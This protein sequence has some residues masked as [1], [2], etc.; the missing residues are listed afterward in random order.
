MEDIETAGEDGERIIY[1]WMKKIH[2]AGVGKFYFKK[3]ILFMLFKMAPFCN[4]ITLRYF[5][6]IK[7]IML[8]LIF[9]GSFCNVCRRDKGK[10]IIDFHRILSSCMAVVEYIRRKKLLVHSNKL[11]WSTYFPFLQ[12]KIKS[13]MFCRK[14][15]RFVA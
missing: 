11:H 2:V 12:P 1:P 4:I 3:H 10:E 6:I 7:N 14:S 5:C 8:N 13:G 9:R 15:S